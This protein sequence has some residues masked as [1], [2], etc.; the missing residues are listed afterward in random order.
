M[1]GMARS[2]RDLPD[3]LD[4]LRAAGLELQFIDDPIE[5]RPGDDGVLSLI[6]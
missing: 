6:S 2:V 5:V 4:Q 3:P 1:S